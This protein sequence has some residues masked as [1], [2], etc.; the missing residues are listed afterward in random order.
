MGGERESN[1]TQWNIFPS[2]DLVTLPLVVVWYDR[3]LTFQPNLL[4][5]LIYCE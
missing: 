2:A 3:H 5:L 4:L 1:A